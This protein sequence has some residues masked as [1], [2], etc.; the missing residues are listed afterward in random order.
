MAQHVGYIVG[1][2]KPVYVLPRGYLWPAVHYYKNYT[3]CNKANGCGV[4]VQA[5]S[6]QGLFQH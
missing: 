3:H 5:Q 1:A 6:G 2:L 4:F